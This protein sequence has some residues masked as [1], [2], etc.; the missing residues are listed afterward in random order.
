MA[1]RSAQQ[2]LPVFSRLTKRTD[3]YLPSMPRTASIRLLSAFALILLCL[4]SCTKPFLQ[5]D[6]DGA[7]L[8]GEWKRVEVSITC[9]WSYPWVD[10]SQT[11][12]VEDSY[13]L[14]IQKNGRVI[15]T[16]PDVDWCNKISALETEY[17]NSE[18]KRL[19]IKWKNEEER[20]RTGVYLKGDS[21]YMLK[22]PDPAPDS[23]LFTGQYA[24]YIRQ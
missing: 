23:N 11:T 20:T 13:R 14:E 15:S 22:F 5:D 2:D 6:A 19:S 9:D 4:P 8:V 21:L 1:L 17:Q 12:H 24:L 3:N 16:G 18:A 10:C 7:G